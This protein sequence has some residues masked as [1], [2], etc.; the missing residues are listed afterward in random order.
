MVIGFLVLEILAMSPL[1]VSNAIKVGTGLRIVRDLI[2]SLQHMV[3]VGLGMKSQGISHSKNFGV[4]KKKTL[5]YL[6]KCTEVECSGV[7]HEVG[8]YWQYC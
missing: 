6:A 2:P 8:D 1:N 5:K 7:C 3:A 4:R